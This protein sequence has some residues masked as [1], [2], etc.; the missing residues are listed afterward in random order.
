MREPTDDVEK[1]HQDDETHV[2]F[3]LDNNKYS[4]APADY[5]KVIVNTKSS[6]DSVD[7]TGEGDQETSSD[8]G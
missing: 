6:F 7:L 2:T 3:D 1:K 5:S 4:D 8:A